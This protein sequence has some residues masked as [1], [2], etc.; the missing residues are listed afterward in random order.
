MVEPGGAGSQRHIQSCQS[1]TGCP[2]SVAM[3]PSF[4]ECRLK[5][6]SF[7][8]LLR[9]DDAMLKVATRCMARPLR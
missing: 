8:A 4:G 3:R 7:I 9:M 6:I 2:V 5:V 1:L